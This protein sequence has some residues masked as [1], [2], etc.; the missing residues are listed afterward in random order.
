M[1]ELKKRIVIASVLKPVSDTRM[2]EK[3]AATLSQDAAL[4]VHVIGYPASYSTNEKITLHSFA[5]FGRLSLKRLTT[6]IKILQI[7][8]VLKPSV[9]IVA[10]HELLG[11]ALLAKWLTRTKVV[12]DVQ[13]NYYLNILHTNAFSGVLK[14]PIAWY[15]RLK[16][17]FSRSWVDHFF[18]AEEIYAQQLPFARGRSTILANKIT[19]DLTSITKIHNPFALIFSGTLSRSTGVFE[20]IRLA[21]ELHK[22]EPRITLTLIGYAALESELRPIQADIQNRPFITLV[23]G[24]RPVNHQEIVKA[25]A[26]SG[27]GVVAYESN[28]ATEGRIPT[29]LYEYIGAGLPI[30]FTR[31]YPTWEM[32]TGGLN[33]P[34]IR[35]DPGR[36]DFSSIFEWLKLS[37]HR[38]TFPETVLWKTEESK[39]RTAISTL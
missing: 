24:N 8:C 34:S 9:L 20:A 12:Y 16:E 2:T 15:V 19:M 37:K 35:I 11:I 17:I 29:K 6:P 13:E 3:I 33:H 38:E 32:L 26:Q 5:P 25:I 14:F 23:G 4:D 31:S 27:A 39:L 36:A 1:A 28:P 21:S 18:L 10:T 30:I 7:I 22:V